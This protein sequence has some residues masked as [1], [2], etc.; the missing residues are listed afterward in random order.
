LLGRGPALIG[1]SSQYQPSFRAG[2]G[3]DMVSS[4]VPATR[5]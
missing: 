1:V 4:P 3:Q 2:Q 5:A